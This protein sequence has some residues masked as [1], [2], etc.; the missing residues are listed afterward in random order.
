M[1]IG[2]LEQHVLLAIVAQHPD[3]YGVSIHK[4]VADLSDPKRVSLGAV[5][6]ALDRLEDK[7]MITS[8]LADPTPERGGRA[9][10][11]FR[12]TAK[13]IREVRETQHVLVKLWKGVPEL[14][15]GSA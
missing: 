11:Y 6:V 4:R 8:A 5:Y 1:N 9:K 3:A 15:G 2:A 13:G 7:G 10:R 12:I 14:K